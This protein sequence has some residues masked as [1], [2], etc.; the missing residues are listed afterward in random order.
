MEVLHLREDYGRSSRGQSDS[1]VAGRKAALEVLD[2]CLFLQDKAAF[3]RLSDQVLCDPGFYAQ[4]GD[5]IVNHAVSSTSKTGDSALM[6]N[7]V[8]GYLSHVKEAAKG[9]TENRTLGKVFWKDTTWYITLRA[10]LKKKVEERCIKTAQ[11]ISEK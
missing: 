6:C 8:L 5:Y 11:P 2:R 9:K 4:F 1:S 10:S 7:T 3:A